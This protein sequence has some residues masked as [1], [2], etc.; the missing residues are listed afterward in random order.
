MCGIAGL[1]SVQSERGIADVCV[2]MRDAMAHRGPDDAGVYVD[3]ECRVALA[4][5][6]LAII[7]LSAAGHQPMA[8]ADGRVVV[9]FNGEIYNYR[10]LRAELLGRGVRLVSESDTEVII[11]LYRELGPDCLTRLNGMFGLAIWDADRRRLTLARDRLGKKPVL[12][13]HLADGTLA[14]AS[15]HQGLLEH[16][17]IERRASPTAIDSFLRYGYVPAPLS[18]FE[19]VA[20]LPPGHRLLW[21]DGRL[22]VEAYWEPPV[23]R[24]RAISEEVA[25]A[26]LTELLSDSVK[27]RMIADVP[28]GAFLS[29]GID[30]ASVVALMAEHS[31]RPVRTFS[32]GFG[33]NG[34]NELP[35]ARLTAERYATEHH[36]FVVEPRAAE[37]LSDLVRHYGEPYAD[38]SALPTYYLS[39]LTRRHVTVALNGDGGD[40]V[41][42]G[43]DRYRA[44]LAAERLVGSLPVPKRAYELVAAALPAGGDL[45]T[46]ATRAKRFVAGLADSTG[47]RYTRWMS[48]FEPELL[49]ACA[50]PTLATASERSSAAEYLVAPL[51][52]RNGTDLLG[53]LTRLDLMTYLPGD[54]L[55]KA[56]I[57]TMACSLEGRSPFLDYRLVEWAAT[58]PPQLR[59]RGQ[60]GKYLLRRA[61]RERLPAATLSGPKRGFGV[62]VAAW[63]RGELRPMLLDTVLS[64]RALGRGY[65]RPQAVRR[66]VGEHL[67]GRVD[68]A[69]QLW[70]LLCLELWHRAFLDGA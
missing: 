40:E 8:S 49:R 12:Y 59:L 3:E 32:I 52:R 21:Q 15:E 4:S 64:E 24:P 46:P 38:S 25:V 51:D 1:V 29:G 13:A 43:Y 22:T 69:K 36:E 60:T 26:E 62:P 63:L 37:V 30:S 7:D 16:P 11:H 6:R 34:Y 55:V 48:V 68:R 17:R 44:A 28:L 39:K 65:L 35:G 57:A 41:L 18:G 9:V 20:K 42:A 53:A 56:D 5:R 2:A 58:L 54:L 27:R 23:A 66:L 33:E 10:E 31:D 45:R 14:F 67:E 47:A 70:A 50:G 19:C 61:M